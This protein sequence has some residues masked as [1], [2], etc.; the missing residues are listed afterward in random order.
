MSQV[1]PSEYFVKIDDSAAISLLYE[2]PAFELVYSEQ[3]ENSDDTRQK[4]LTALQLSPIWEI[5]QINIDD[6]AESSI[7]KIKRK[8]CKY[9]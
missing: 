6:L 9:S 5:K 8:C 7:H 4:I 1:V 2:P 3:L